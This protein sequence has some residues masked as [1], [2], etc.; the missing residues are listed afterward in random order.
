MTNG[1]RNK[2]INGHVIIA[3]ITNCHTSTFTMTKIGNLIISTLATKFVNVV[4]VK[5]LNLLLVL[6]LVRSD[7][8]QVQPIVFQNKF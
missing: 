6:C 5:E 7:I 1:T 3:V 8:M 4:I 2:I